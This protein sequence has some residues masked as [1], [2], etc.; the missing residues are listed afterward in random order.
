MISP[1]LPSYSRAPLSF[2]K[3]EGAWLVEADGRRF[4]DFASGIAVMALGHG[5]PALVN[6]LKSQAEKLWHTSNLYTVP[7]Q[8]EL[9]EKLVEHTFADTM[10]FCNSGTEAGELAV[11][12]ARKYWHEKGQPDR[13]TIITFEGAFHGRSMGMISAAGAEK[14]TVGFGPLLP[15]FIHLSFGDHD[16]LREAAARTD[17]GAIMLEPIQGESGIRPVPDQCLKGLRDLCYEHGL[18]LVF[19]EIQCGM[20]RTGKLFAHEWA[21][22]SPDIMMVAKG[23]GGGFPIGALLATEEAAIGMTPGTHGSTYGGNPL[24]CA[25]AATVMDVITEDGFLEDVSRRAGLL[26]QKAEGLVASHPEVFE[27]VRGA[28]FMLGLVCKLPNLDVINAAF[29]QEMLT[30]P[31]GDNVVR[32][33][34]SLTL[35]EAEIAEGIDRLDR[36][37]TALKAQTHDAAE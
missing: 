29:E 31:A 4:L 24:G 17:V 16:A 18:L 14:L 3:G 28:G 32:L 35:S 21:G 25:V 37:A 10:F 5:H 30:V 15:G 9:A 22:I 7:E 12:M 33:L 19:D 34:P 6:T 23:I 27:E 8:Q 36:A 11:K 1:V 26:R 2:V 20:G 13:T